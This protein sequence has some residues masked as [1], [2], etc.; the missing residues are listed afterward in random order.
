MLFSINNNFRFSPATVALI[1]FFSSVIALHIWGL[2]PYNQLDP[3]VYLY[4]LGQAK[5]MN[6]PQ[7]Q[8]LAKMP[9]YNLFSLDILTLPVFNFFVGLL[10]K[11]L[12]TL[13]GILIVRFFIKNDLIVILFLLV[14]TVG[15]YIEP[16]S[17]QFTIK[18]PTYF[19]FRETGS[20][21]ILLAIWCALNRKWFFSGSFF[22]ICLL[23]HP[24]IGLLTPLLVAPMLILSKSTNPLFSY[25]HRLKSLSKIAVPFL[26]FFFIAF[27]TSGY[28]TSLGTG[29]VNFPIQLFSLKF[30]PD[31]YFLVDRI[32]TSSEYLIGF[33]QNKFILSLG[34]VTVFLIYFLTLK[35]SIENSYG[36][37]TTL[38]L[39]IFLFLIT[40]YVRTSIYL[41]VF[42]GFV[43]IFIFRSFR[44]TDENDDSIKN[45][46][47][48]P[49]VVFTG[50]TIFYFFISLIIESRYGGLI[51]G[52]APVYYGIDLWFGL[53]FNT[54]IATFLL[55][56]VIAQILVFLEERIL[57]K[58]IS[59]RKITL[60]TLF[61]FL[62]A[63]IISFWTSDTRQKNSV[64]GE[65]I[66]LSLV[67]P[68]DKEFIHRQSPLE[69]IYEENRY[70]EEG[71]SKS[72][73][74][75]RQEI[76]DLNYEILFK[77]DEY[78]LPKLEDLEIGNSR[79]LSRLKANALGNYYAASGQMW[80]SHA[81]FKKANDSVGVFNSTPILKDNLEI[82]F[83]LKISYETYMNALDWIRKE[84][85]DGELILNAPH[86]RMANFI[87][88][89][90]FFFQIDSSFLS[91]TLSYQWAE[92]FL[93]RQR[94][95]LGITILD[96]PGF[97][98][99]SETHEFRYAF[100][101]LTDNDLIRILDLYPEIKYIFTE[102]NHNLN[103]PVLFVN[104][105][106]V[107][108]ELVGL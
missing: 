64:T 80:K 20:L 83:P 30:Y 28:S 49:L 100:L 44:I 48:N 19:H 84:I 76:I 16:S 107:V 89:K 1:C 106:F 4:E 102:K 25:E 98:K 79:Y 72:F 66:Y 7:F 24:G 15:L 14:L 87:A 59:K 85:S 13:F 45:Y 11:F 69:N 51:T 82:D 99:T 42:L 23:V 81:F 43:N 61:F 88:S 27:T 53:Y 36:L 9:I 46:L 12:K 67:N 35:S 105:N 86:F 41:L 2:M 90:N 73:N 32:A 29:L 74:T 52:L 18:H 71:S 26:F 92:K 94:N 50:T 62:G 54:L 70:L 22:G 5:G 47:R 58:P 91:A 38:I 55:T 104:D 93:V 3:F 21:L 40:Y 65:E 68:S 97:K 57:R 6:H 108:Y 56:L 75:I 96:V 34:I 8:Y 10:V 95:I 37:S 78:T 101:S 77:R 17:F 103:L 31:D 60:I 33:S 39:L 63:A